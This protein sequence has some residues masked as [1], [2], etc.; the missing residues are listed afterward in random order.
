MTDVELHTLNRDFQWIDA[1]PSQRRRLTAAEIAQFNAK[2]F[3]KLE[4]VFTPAEIQDVIEAIDPL[5][6]QEEMRLRQEGGT[7]F[8]SKADVITFT[9]H[10]VARSAILRE[11]AAHPAIKDICADLVGDDVRLYWDQSVYKKAAEE[12]EFPW[13]Q[14][15]GYTFVEPQAYLTLWIPLN[16]VDDTNGCPWIVPGLHKRGTLRHWPSP[17]GH[18]CLEDPDDQV[19]VPGKAGDIIAFSSLAPHRTGPNLR[20]GTIRKAYIL[21]YAPDGACTVVNGVRTPQDDPGR[22]FAILRGGV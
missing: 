22:Q 21:Q 5:E 12:R 4:Q 3:V 13:H 18:V 9:V 2:G 8:V 16:E 1:A 7:R 15:N 20:R 10:L 6:A 17:I 11:F 19:C 14:D